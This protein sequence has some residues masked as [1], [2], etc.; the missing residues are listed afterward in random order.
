MGRT[1]FEAIV[2]GGIGVSVD[3]LAE[4]TTHELAK[5]VKDLV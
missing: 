3:S 4:D 5:A 1:V 2:Q